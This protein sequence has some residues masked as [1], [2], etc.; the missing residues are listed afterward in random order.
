MSKLR[1]IAGPNGSGKSSI[2]HLIKEFKEK[3]RVIRT[4]PFVNS[5]VIEKEF[6][7]KGSINLRSFQIESPPQSLIADYLKSSNFTG[8]YDPK[9]ISGELVLDGDFLKLRSESS[10][11]RLNPASSHKKLQAKTSDCNPCFEA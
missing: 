6:K 8:L 3:Q 9:I 10:L 1:V 5:D 2:F 11:L 7:D 4:G